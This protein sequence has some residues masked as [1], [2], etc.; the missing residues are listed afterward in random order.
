MNEEVAAVVPQSNREGSANIYLSN[1]HFSVALCSI[2][3]QTP[4]VVALFETWSSENDPIHLFEISGYEKIITKITK[5]D[6]VCIY[7]LSDCD[8]MSNKVISQFKTW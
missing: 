6:G 8:V 1:R 2:P 5:G 3:S 7:V 4:A